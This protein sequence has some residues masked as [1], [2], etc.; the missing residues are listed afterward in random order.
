M[1]NFN[2]NRTSAV[3]VMYS[4][5]LYFL[6]LSLRSTSKILSIFSDGN[7]SYVY[8]WNWIQHFGLLAKNRIGGKEYLYLSLMNFYQNKTVWKHYFLWV[9]TESV[10]H[11]ILG[12][13]IQR[14]ER[15]NMLVAAQCIESL[16]SKYGKHPVYSN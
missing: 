11:S 8:V 6:G 7:R 13:F 15:R 16:I 5:Y 4:L 1:I 14:S 3:V 10:H 2:R 9:A 12:I